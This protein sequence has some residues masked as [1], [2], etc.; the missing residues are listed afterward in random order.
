MTAAKVGAA[1][2]RDAVLILSD[3]E[4]AAEAALGGGKQKAARG[5]FKGES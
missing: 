3:A 5:G 4:N 2:W 1:A